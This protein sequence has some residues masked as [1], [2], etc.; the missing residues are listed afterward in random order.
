MTAKKNFIPAFTICLFFAVTPAKAQYYQNDILA[1]KAINEEFAKLKIQQFKFIKLSS[2]DENDQPSEGFFCE[3]KIN[4]SFLQSEMISR[5]DIS[6]ESLVK[7]TYNSKGMIEKAENTTPYSNNITQ[8]NYDSEGKLIK[9]NTVT[10]GDNDSVRIVETREYSYSSNGLPI[11][12]V[13][14]KDN[15]LIGIINFI[16]DEKG[17]VIE[18][19]GKGYPNEI[20]YYY[21][22][23][24]ENR[25]TDIV[26]FN[27]IAAKL[28]PDYMFEYEGSQKQPKQMIS[29]N[30]DG[31]NYYIWRYA[32][33]A[34]GLPEIQKC[35]SKERKLLGTIQFDYK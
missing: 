23:D 20:K 17:N 10:F 31:R 27:P 3:K 19:N 7:S 22:Y 35:F 25:I 4:P 2:F 30:Q 12:M 11:K 18:E 8:Y 14:K 6:G 24:A 29:V 5:S 15:Q 34:S 16:S 33:T 13:R 32:Y 26:H 21:Y 28:L 9:I 1:T